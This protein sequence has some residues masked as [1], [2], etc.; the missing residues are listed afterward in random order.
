MN[1]SSLHQNA[2]VIDCHCDFLFES[3]RTGRR[4]ADDTAGHISLGK[5]RRGGYNAQFF[6]VYN[7]WAELPQPGGAAAS[8]Q[9]AIAAFRAELETHPQTLA[10]ATTTAEIKAATA[11]GKI[12]CILSLEGAEPLAGNVRAVAGMYRQGVRSIGLV[13]NYRNRAADGLGVK[14]PGGLTDFGRRLVA[15]MD[16][17]GILIDIAHLAPPG[18]EEVFALTRRPVIATHANAQRICPAP[19][20]LS[21]R[22]LDLLARSGGVIGVT[23]VPDFITPAGAPATVSQLVKH[24]SYI[25]HRIGAEYIAL[26]SDFDG[27]SDLTAGLEDAAQLPNL[28]AALVEHGYT[29]PEIEGL[30]GLNI[31]RVFRQVAG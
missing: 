29:Q 14:N 9:K 16:R 27:Y 4:L 26:G 12:A 10:Q 31:L 8:A 7:R 15:E 13:W 5:L 17:L 30:L 21:D 1:A 2:T 25:K 19:R 11:E 18:V 24:I 23:F 3:L 6:A 22:Q 28:T 20:N